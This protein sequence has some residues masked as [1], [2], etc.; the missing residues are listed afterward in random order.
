MLSLTVSERTREIG[1]RAAL[2]ATPR[3]LV[4]TVLRRSLTQI[5]VGGL[6][7]VPLAGW[8]IYALTGGADAGSSLVISILVAVGLATS[9]VLVVGVCSCLVPTRRVLAVEASEAM[10][11]DS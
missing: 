4:V 6:I 8:M 3:S 2:G 5:G 10:R 9:I 11:A 7:G 1:I